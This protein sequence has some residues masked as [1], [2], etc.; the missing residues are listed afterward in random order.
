MKKLFAI[1][2]MAFLF[3]GCSTQ[4]YLVSNTHNPSADP[5]YDKFQHFFVAGIGQ[6]Q[7]QDTTEICGS[8]DNVSKVQTKQSFLNWLVGGISYS[9]YTPRDIR[10]FCKQPTGEKQ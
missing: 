6:Q 1:A 5:D 2:C 8:A 7:T 10:V 3:T 9:I 4:T